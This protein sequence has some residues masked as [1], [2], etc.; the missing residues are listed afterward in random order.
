MQNTPAPHLEASARHPRVSAR[1]VEHPLS[2]DR[3]VAQVSDPGVGGVALFMGLV[4]RRDAGREVVA[5][6]YSA[7]PSAQAELEAVCR[8]VADR[9]DIE[10][11]AAE[12]R[13]G[14]LELGEIA[15]VLGAG[16]EHRAAA[17]AACSDLIDTLKQRVPIWKQQDFV[18]GASEWVG[19]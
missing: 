19:L 1:I 8:E 16:A 17:L 9:H 3:V 7:H 15:V 2:L 5:L 14:H 4:R 12:H 6:D 11:V 18:D 10:A 13:V